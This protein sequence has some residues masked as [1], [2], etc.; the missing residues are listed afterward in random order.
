MIPVSLPP[1]ARRALLRS[2]VAPRIQVE[3]AVVPQEDAQRLA[4]FE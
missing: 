2:V 4:A 1:L 3:L